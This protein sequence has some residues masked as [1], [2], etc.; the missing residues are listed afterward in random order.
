MALHPFKVAPL[1]YNLLVY[2]RAEL[3]FVHSLE[4]PGQRVQV[5]VVLA[6]QRDCPSVVFHA[7]AEA[8]S[9]LIVTGV[10]GLDAHR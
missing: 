5:L 8:L 3:L 10:V 9:V 4:Y 2:P 7:G 1:N 6:A